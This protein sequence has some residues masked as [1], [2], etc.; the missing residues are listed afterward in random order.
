MSKRSLSM[1]N[2]PTH[3]RAQTQLTLLRVAATFLPAPRPLVLLGADSAR[4]LCQTMAQLGLRR[5]LIVTDGGLVQL[6]LIEPLVRRLKREGLP[7]AIF[8]GVIPDPTFSVVDTGLAKLISEQCDAVLAVG[9]GSSIDAGKVIALAAGNGKAPKKLVGVLK[10]RKPAL[11]LF[12]VPTTAGTGSEVTVGAVISDDQ[13]H[14]KHLVIDPKVVPQ[15]AA[16]DPRLMQGLP[17]R[18]TADTGIDALT[19]ALEAWVSRF[20]N[21]ETDRYAGAAVR[22]VFAN[23]RKAYSDGSDLAAREAMALAAHYAGFAL[24]QAGLGYVHAIAHQ[25]GARYGLPHGRANAVV[26]PHILAFNRKA[27]QSR[28]AALAELTGLAGT[29]MNKGEAAGRLIQQVQQLLADLGI[30]SRVPGVARDDFQAIIKGAFAEA[31]GTYAVPRYMGERD[32]RRVLE[33]LA[34]A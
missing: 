18:V 31:H 29:G 15:A 22:L 33:S 19:H 32:C 5:P 7:C 26:L 10:A 11:P 2:L 25:L 30:E 16:L 4:K 23:L 1:L 28:L 17:P 3:L 8:D 9:G 34:G 24:N 20:A 12:A 6:G 27:S 13:D 21:A 14:Q